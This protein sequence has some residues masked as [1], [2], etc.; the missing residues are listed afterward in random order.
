VGIDIR[1]PIGLMFTAL[2][3][4]VGG[5]GLASGASL[6]IGINVNLWWG[7]GALVFGLTMLW[8]GRRGRQ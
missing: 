1:I 6:R 4:L 8:F 7:A 3:L 5:Y 2:G